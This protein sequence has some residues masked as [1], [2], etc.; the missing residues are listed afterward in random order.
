MCMR[1]ARINKYKYVV[2]RRKRQ[3]PG[4]TTAD[5]RAY[6]ARV[7]VRYYGGD[8]VNSSRAV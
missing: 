6:T 7:T 4:A 8:M 2:C 3:T 5:G 1:Y